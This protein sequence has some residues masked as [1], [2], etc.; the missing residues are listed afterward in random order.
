MQKEDFALQD[1]K[2]RT[3]RFKRFTKRKKRN[4]ETRKQ[5]K[6]RSGPQNSWKKERMKTTKKKE[7]VKK[8]ISNPTK[9]KKNKK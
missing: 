8:Y 2:E 1:V 5:I 9:E 6:Q 3:E 7:R 4:T